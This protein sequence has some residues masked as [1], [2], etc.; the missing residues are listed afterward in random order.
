V[1]HNTKS[2]DSN[3]F[4]GELKRRNVYKVAAVYA[5]TAWLLVQTALTLLPS[6]EAPTWLIPGLVVFLVFGFALIVYISW[7]FE[8]TPEGM[9][10]TENVSPTEVLPSWSARKFA[11]LIITIALLAA[12]LLVFDFL[13]SKPASPPPTAAP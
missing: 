1:W 10:R 12:S 5:V 8:A 6:V 11:V 7:A 3:T 9:K 13:R 2:M 4:F